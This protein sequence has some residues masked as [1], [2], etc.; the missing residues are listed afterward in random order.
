[1]K[2]ADITYCIIVLSQSFNFYY[3]LTLC[4][5]YVNCFMNTRYILS[6]DYL[7]IYKLINNARLFS[8]QTF[9][10]ASKTYE[11]QVVFKEFHIH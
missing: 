2:P 4:D 10:L 8:L 7:T 6:A 1:M 3:L 11:I 9:H 5:I